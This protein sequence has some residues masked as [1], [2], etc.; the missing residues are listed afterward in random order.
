MNDGGWK[1]AIQALLADL[2][3]PMDRQRSKKKN[4]KRK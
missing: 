1:K 2:P 4:G 3:M